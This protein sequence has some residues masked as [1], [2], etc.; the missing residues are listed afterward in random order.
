MKDNAKP[1]ADP[2]RAHEFS[3]SADPGTSAERENPTRP[4]EPSASRTFDVW[5]ALDIITLR[6][7][8]LIVGS[9]VFA[10]GFY[11]LGWYFIRPKFVATTELLRYEAPGKSDFFKTAPLS[12]ETFAAMMR[13][14]ELLKA[15]AEKAEPPLSAEALSKSIKIDP[16]ADSDMV[17]VQLAAREPRRAVDLLNTYARQV[18]EFTKKLERDQAGML[19]NDYLKK[20]VDEM[21]EDINNLQGQFLKMGVSPL[22]TNK[23]AQFGGQLTSL[24]T[25][26]S[27]APRPSLINFAQQAQRLQTATSELQD[28]LVKYTD[29]NP[30]V[31]AKRDYI[32]DLERQM[33]QASTNGSAMAMASVPLATGPAGGPMTPQEEIVHIKLRALEDSRLE[34]LKRQ[35]EA[36][37]YA[38]DP[39]GSVRIFAPADA[40]STKTNLRPLKISLVT[41]VGAG[42][43]FCASLILVFLVEFLDN[44][45]KTAED[46]RR[47]THLDVLASLG[48]LNEMGPDARAQWAFRAWTMLQ[49]RLS[50]S[51]N[52]GLVCGITSST[53]GEG[54]ST[55]I[56]L[57]AE[58]ASMTG[59]RVLTIATRPSP[60][61]VGSAEE[62]LLADGAGESETDHNFFAGKPHEPK[63]NGHTNGHN[64][65]IT[66]SV[67]SSP[68]KVTEQLT[69]PNSQPVVHIPLPGW[70]WNLERRKQWREALG[71]W[72]QIDNLVILVELPP[73]SVPEAVLLGSNLPNML[74]LADSGTPHAGETRAQLKTLRD[75]RCNLVGAVLNRKASLSSRERFPR[76]MGCFLVLA[77]LSGFVSTAH[78]QTTNAPAPLAETS[79]NHFAEDSPPATGSFSIENPSQRAQWQRHFTLGP[80]DVLTFSLYGQPELTRPE[81]PIGPDGRVNYLQAT[82]VLATGL[83][84]DELRAKI[85]EQLGLYIRSPRTII[86]PVAFKSKKY[87][88]L[89]KVT[90]KGVYTLDRPLTV[91][92]ALA[93][94][95]GLESALVDRDV[96][97]LTDFQRSFLARGGK[98]Y[99]LNFERLFE[100]GDLSQNIAVEPG[101]YIYFAAGDVND[102]YVVGE[103]RSPGTVTYTPNMTVIEAIAGR[104]GYTDRAFR[105]RVLVI[106]GSLDNPEKFAVNTHAILDAREP[107]FKLRPRDII[108][109][110]SRPFIKVEEA[111]DLATTAFIQSLIFSWVG[112]DV[113]QPLP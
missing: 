86:L 28:L 22:V 56:S 91:L 4:E 9:L 51:P 49:G 5:S 106:R 83:T 35:R 43:G 105:A 38:T 62:H 13:S 55:W 96:V 52:F 93:R 73:A 92:E 108:F 95:H 67:L 42:L 17:K 102:V 16:E 24:S 69:G 79:T 97:S 81:V 101:D 33:Q 41:I 12:S 66:T 6:W 25:N 48:D 32:N 20:Q 21:Q 58:A 99:P 39:T 37:L 87:Y 10:T 46:I 74:W 110:N 94:A 63:T 11:L 23:L 104:G 107:N 109:V 76:W 36:E 7:H 98:R 70:V 45:M 59:F 30:L 3:A 84:I 64:Q 75:A 89:G 90:T 18:V 82:N 68:S 31:Q 61:H 72:R 103:V 77:T 60:T 112:V 50:P 100:R 57:M 54:R 40:N 44:R 8:W 14:P 85:D 65:S 34:L 19:A 71:Q 78:A 88:M 111:A 80:G 26:L 53:P 29:L 113:V 2:L 27:T 15:V 1:S 47:V